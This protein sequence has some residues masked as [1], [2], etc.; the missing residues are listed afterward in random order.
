MI[1]FGWKL[2]NDVPQIVLTWATFFG[3]CFIFLTITLLTREN[4]KR[5]RSIV[6][7][8]F[9]LNLRSSNSARTDVLVYVIS[10]L[11][12][13]IPEIPGQALGLFLSVGVAGLLANVFP[14]YSSVE[15]T[16]FYILASGLAIFLVGEFAD[17]LIHY[18]EHKV[19]VLWELHKTHHSATSLNPLTS[20]RGH[21]VSDAYGGVVRG[22]FSCLPV[23]A[24]MFMFNL[25]I[26]EAAALG[27]VARRCCTML[28]LDPLRHSPFPVSFGWGDRIFISPHM[29]HVHHSSLQPHLDT[30]F[31][32]NLSIFDWLFGT[33]YKPARGE[34]IEY[35]LAGKSREETESFQSLYGF[36]IRPMI[37]VA[38]MT[39]RSAVRFVTLTRG[40]SPI[41][42]GSQPD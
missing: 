34:K 19:P 30:N 37:K 38:N 33:A 5:F 40:P 1:E 14:G 25:T 26:V 35:G 39:S 2:V 27:A 6:K 3:A 36:Y 23:G 12:D 32:T 31:G 10:K 18:S 17:Y 20:Q 7:D 15:L 28:T 4:R 42:P 13:F 21:S 11:T 41:P 16:S 29:H 9:P 22:L 24:V 8:I